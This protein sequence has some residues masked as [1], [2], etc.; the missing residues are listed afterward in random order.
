MSNSLQPSSATA[1]SSSN[2]P[3]VKFIDLDK[4][5]HNNDTQYEWAGKIPLEQFP[6]LWAL[7]DSNH[8]NDEP[9]D[10]R[11][12]VEKRGE[13]LHWHLQT[14]GVIWQTCQRCL[15]PVA[16]DLYI[17]S[18]LA[19]LKNE[20]HV[21]LLDEETETILLE[22]ILDGNKLWLLPMIE[23]ELLV[24]LPL[25]PK[26]EDCEMAVTQIGELPEESEE[27]ASPFALLASLKGQLKS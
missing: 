25:S 10:I 14:D 13:I 21:A 15:E 22:E 17:D 18:E 4:W 6:R 16:V 24:E 8:S 20:S 7:R 26:H 12:T 23:D 5:E 2:V 1:T 9:L 3:L 11:L 19:L 27:K